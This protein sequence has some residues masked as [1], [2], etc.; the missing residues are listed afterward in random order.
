M[1]DW[2]CSRAHRYTGTACVRATRTQ[3]RAASP[4][5]AHGNV[6]ASRADTT[7]QLLPPLLAGADIA[8]LS[9]CLHTVTRTYSVYIHILQRLKELLLSEYFE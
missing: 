6:R 8:Y 4:F 9:G 7:R 1:W 2:F 3:A 5:A